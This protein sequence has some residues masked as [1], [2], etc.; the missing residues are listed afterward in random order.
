MDFTNTKEELILSLKNDFGIHN[1]EVLEALK[2]VPREEFLPVKLKQYAYLNKAL[3]IAENQTISQPLIVALMT[4]A[5]DLA[6][7]DK[8]LE[9]GTGSGY[10]AAI[11]SLLSQ[12]VVSIE[13]FKK[14]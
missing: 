4:Q 12:K 14:L 5:L 13:Y 2:K 1:V 11:L 6:K 7:T 3:L 10:Q 9:I 8:V